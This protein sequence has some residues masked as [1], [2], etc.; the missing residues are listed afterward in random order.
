MQELPGSKYRAL[1][2]LAAGEAE[3]ECAAETGFLQDK[4]S[5]KM[6]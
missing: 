2:K 5:G 6:L 3:F 4:F 1:R